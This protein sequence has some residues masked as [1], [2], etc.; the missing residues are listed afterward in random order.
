M[1]FWL[2]F[3]VL[4]LGSHTGHTFHAG[5]LC[6][7]FHTGAPFVSSCRQLTP[8][9][10]LRCTHVS[11]LCVW[12]LT[13][14]DSMNKAAI[15]VYR[16]VFMR[17]LVFKPMER[18]LRSATAGSHGNVL[19]NSILKITKV[20]RYDVCI[21]G[22]PALWRLRQ[23]RGHQLKA[24]G[25]CSKSLSQKKKKKVKRSKVRKE[26]KFPTVFDCNYTMSVFPLQCG[27]MPLTPWFGSKWSAGR[28]F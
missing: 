12:L 7:K 15:N 26:K 6:A 14:C 5:F 24:R 8:W 17:T 3:T 21:R 23:L 1:Y 27:N 2:F 18:I 9:I 10:T 25:L 28:G 13:A 22:I 16:Q 20:V 4:Q 11:P 19:F